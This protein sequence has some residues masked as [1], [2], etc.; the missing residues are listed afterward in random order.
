MNGGND[1]RGF[2]GNASQYTGASVTLD[3][4]GMDSVDTIYRM[5]RLRQTY[6]H[7]HL[8]GDEFSG[9]MYKR[10]ASETGRPAEA[11]EGGGALYTRVLCRWGQKLEA[12]Q[13]TMAPPILVILCQV[14]KITRHKR[15]LA[16]TPRKDTPVTNA[17]P[18]ESL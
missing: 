17:S 2:A 1:G 15:R 4:E 18:N 7:G 5:I 6:R 12:G 9:L 13:Y 8:H 10:K 11:G 16:E 3:K 14:S